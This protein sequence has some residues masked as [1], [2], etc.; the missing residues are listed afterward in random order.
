[1]LC[2]GLL[3]LFS[4]VYDYNH[5]NYAATVLRSKVHIEE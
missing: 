5:I 2:Y 3:V 1:M 4:I